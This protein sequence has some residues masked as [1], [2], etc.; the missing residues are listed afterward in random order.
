[1]ELEL[2]E[3][4]GAAES[5]RP[6]LK[7]LNHLYPSSIGY[8]PTRVDGEGPG[9]K[10]RGQNVV[11]SGQG[12]FRDPAPKV[13]SVPSSNLLKFLREHTQ[14]SLYLVMKTTFRIA[15]DLHP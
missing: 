12:T 10:K 8:S 2:C 4:A 15:A 9:Y 3:G 14:W 6:F 11:Q 7:T 1:M 5:Q 13:R